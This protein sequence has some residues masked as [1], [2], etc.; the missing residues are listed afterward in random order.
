MYS[1]TGA[2]AK[3]GSPAP[4]PQWAKNITCHDDSRQNIATA[5]SAACKPVPPHY[6][7]LGRSNWPSGT[8]ACRLQAAGKADTASS[9]ATLAFVA[10]TGCCNKEE[11]RACLDKRDV[12]PRLAGFQ[13]AS[14]MSA[15]RDAAHIAA[16]LPFLPQRSSAEVPLAA[17][18]SGRRDA[19]LMKRRRVEVDPNTSAWA[20]AANCR[21]EQS[22]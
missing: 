9:E 17:S 11:E 12:S 10:L 5:R 4:P 16:R 15:L 13:R 6:Q 3:P 20:R 19:E 21:E 8:Q 1:A 7:T 22:R 2:M 14:S 18:D